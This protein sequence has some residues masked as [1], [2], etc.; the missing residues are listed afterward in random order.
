MVQICK[1]VCVSKYK[2]TQAVGNPK[3]KLKLPKCKICSV[4]IPWDGNMC[5]CC[6]A[7]LS[8]RTNAKSVSK[9]SVICN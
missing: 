6:G 8:R 4:R 3:L 2:A 7:W 1:G 9:I 5:P